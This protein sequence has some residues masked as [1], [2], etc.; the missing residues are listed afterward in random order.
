[1][2]HPRVGTTGSAAQHLAIGHIPAAT[3]TAAQ[4]ATAAGAAPLW[5]E[6]YYWIVTRNTWAV[7]DIPG[8]QH[9]TVVSRVPL[10]Q[11][12][13][14][15]L[16]HQKFRPV[17]RKV[18]S[19]GRQWYTFHRKG[20]ATQ[21]IALSG[22]PYSTAYGKA[23]VME[24]C[25]L[26]KFS[27]TSKIPN[28]LLFTAFHKSD[29][30]WQWAAKP[31]GSF[32][33]V[34]EGS[35]DDGAP[36][37]TWDHH[38]GWNQQFMLYFA[39][40]TPPLP[41]PPPPPPP[42]DPLPPPDDPSPPLTPDLA[43]SGNPTYT[44]STQQITANFRNQGSANAGSFVVHM[45][46]NNYVWCSNTYTGLAVGQ[47]TT[48]ACDMSSLASGTYTYQVVLDTYSTVAESNESNNEYH[49]YFTK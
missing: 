23:L 19:E 27:I 44:A 8:A 10:Q 21:C 25:P 36:I 2:L 40:S 30:W 42:D 13:Q 24:N 45:A 46:I 38:D 3:E 32:W 14:N 11:W 29:G 28:H 22:Y 33:D 39:E 5:P 9:P 20:H 26:F 16:D 34:A 49:S 37:I 18:D 12:T 7:F 6:A 15:G 17:L 31:W 1:M 48:F 43:L 4:M 41:A 35:T 47:S